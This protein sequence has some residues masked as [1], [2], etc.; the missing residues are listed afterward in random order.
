[1]RLKRRIK[2]IEAGLRQKGKV[3]PDE[4]VRVFF[5]DESGSVRVQMR[6]EKARVMKNYT[7]DASELL[8]IQ[9]AI[10]E[11]RPRPVAV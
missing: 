3:P 9:S 4:R 2:K 6:A 7:S 1:M 11:P 8:F 5:D 10:H